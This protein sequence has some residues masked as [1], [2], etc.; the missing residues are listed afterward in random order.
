MVNEALWL[1]VMNN[2]RECY[3]RS[4]ECGES[5]LQALTSSYPLYKLLYT[6]VGWSLTYNLSSIKK[7]GLGGD[8]SAKWK[9]KRNFRALILTAIILAFCGL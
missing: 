8:I 6:T 4:V 5:I 7:L 2:K 1:S 3:T 9:P